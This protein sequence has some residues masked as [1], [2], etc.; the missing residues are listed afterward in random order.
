MR[1]RRRWRDGR[2]R[3]CCGGVRRMRRVRVRRRH[4]LWIACCCSY[5]GEMRGIVLE[6]EK[7]AR[8]RVRRRSDPLRR[9]LCLRRGR[10][11][12]VHVRVDGHVSCV[13]AIVRPGRASCASSRRTR[14]LASH[15]DSSPPGVRVHLRVAVLLRSVRCTDRVRAVRRRG[16]R[17]KERRRL[18]GEVLVVAAPRDRV[19][20]VVGHVRRARALCL[21][22]DEREARAV[23][24]E[25][26]RRRVSESGRRRRRRR[27][28]HARDSVRAGRA[29]SHGHSQAG[30]VGRS[31][32]GRAA[33]QSR[34][35]VEGQ[36]VQ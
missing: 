24:V 4:R 29:H 34:L 32:L 8:V 14:T 20:T 13:H 27:A 12:V 35:G 16:R 30:A 36:E 23:R 28:G 9:R 5:G 15:A 18:R 26:R 17:G 7:D 3:G 2:L 31:S 11:R 25:L 19:G 1:R 6:R 33:R 22:R 21:A 10:R